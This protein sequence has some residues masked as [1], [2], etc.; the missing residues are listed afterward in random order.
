MSRLNVI[1]VIE[2]EKESMQRKYDLKVMDLRQIADIS[3]DKWD[4]VMN[5]FYVGFA[6]GRKEA[7]AEYK[8]HPKQLKR[9][10]DYRKA[11]SAVRHQIKNS[12]IL[13]GIYEIESL[14][15][16]RYDDKHYKELSEAENNRIN[17]INTVMSIQNEKHLSDI[18][19]VVQTF[20]GYEK[21]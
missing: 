17:I 6:Q 5:G 10:E 9:K 11:I 12:I 8:T 19:C 1:K 4:L 20:Y 14:Y 16:K 18:L 21:K 2:E 15:Q 3:K 13:K 7:K